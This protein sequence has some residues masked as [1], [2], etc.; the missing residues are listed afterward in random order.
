MVKCSQ[1]IIMVPCINCSKC[2]EW[3]LQ[4]CTLLPH[5]DCLPVQVY[6]SQTLVLCLILYLL[7]RTFQFQFYD[8]LHLLNNIYFKL[9]FFLIKKVVAC[10]NYTLF[11]TRL[12]ILTSCQKKGKDNSKPHKTL[13]TNSSTVLLKLNK[14]N[15]LPQ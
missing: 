7:L 13:K 14:I 11:M 15:Q 4:P 2:K 8:S 1:R 12:R 9:K 5:Q 3:F 6:L 10:K